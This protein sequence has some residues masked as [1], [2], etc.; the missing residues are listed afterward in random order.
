MCD[1]IVA[2]EVY[3]ETHP[4]KSITHTYINMSWTF[5]NMIFYKDVDI[6]LYTVLKYHSQINCYYTQ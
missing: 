4:K 5:H 2:R 3:L 1:F 6:P